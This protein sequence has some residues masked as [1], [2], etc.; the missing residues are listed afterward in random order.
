M[1]HRTA[2][3]TAGVACALTLGGTIIAL[4]SPPVR[5]TRGGSPLL[6]AATGGGA[7]FRGAADRRVSTG[8]PVLSVVADRECYDASL[9]Q[10]TVTVRA[11]GLPEHRR[12]TVLPRVRQQC[13]GASSG[14][15]SMILQF[16][17]HLRRELRDQGYEDIQIR[18]RALVSLNGR[19]RQLLIDPTVDLASEPATIG[20]APWIL[21]LVEPL[22]R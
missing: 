16:A 21:P 10:V 9:D 2:E 17:H 14:D 18:A 13:P 4:A 20:T 22:S 3:R 19:R 6:R 8:G 5:E 1:R 15:P 7:G 12:R 11:D